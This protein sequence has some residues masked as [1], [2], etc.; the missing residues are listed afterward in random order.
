MTLNS[1]GLKYS[2]TFEKVNIFT[3]KVSD[4]NLSEFV[5]VCAL[6]RRPLFQKSISGVTIDSVWFGWRCL[7]TILFILL[8]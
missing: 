7:F 2:K 6:T 8:Y 4:C 3:G 5:G 1:K